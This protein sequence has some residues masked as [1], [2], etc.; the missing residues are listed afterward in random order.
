[1]G[2]WIQPA[3]QRKESTSEWDVREWTK[4]HGRRK[5]TCYVV[6]SLDSSASACAELS[7]IDAAGRAR[8]AP[9]TGLSP[10]AYHLREDWAASPKTWT[11][12]RVS[13]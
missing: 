11:N 1:M 4:A 7:V 9:V 6:V 12:S 10:A 3:L 13:F 8:T 2:I 5:E